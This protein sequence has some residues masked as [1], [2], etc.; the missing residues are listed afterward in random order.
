MLL[1]PVHLGVSV[2]FSLCPAL[3]FRICVFLRSYFALTPVK[4]LFLMAKTRPKNL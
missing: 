4:H 2:I 3:T 1:V